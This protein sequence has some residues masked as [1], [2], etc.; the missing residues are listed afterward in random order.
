[1]VMISKQLY[2]LAKDYLL[3]EIDVFYTSNNF[4]F[5]EMLFKTLYRKQGDEWSNKKQ[6]ITP[7]NISN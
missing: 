6:F 1:M 5:I 2:C 3:P 7:F 4:L